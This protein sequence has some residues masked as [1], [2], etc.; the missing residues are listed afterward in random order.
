MIWDWVTAG[1]SNTLYNKL[2]GEFI[3]FPNKKIVTKKVKAFQTTA[4]EISCFR[5]TLDDD[6]YIDYQNNEDVLVLD[7]LEDVMYFRA[8]YVKKDCL[9]L[10]NIMISE[11]DETTSFLYITW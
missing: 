8:N 6:F 4:D 10:I 11:W 9:E 2:T 1:H 5:C 7:T 3:H